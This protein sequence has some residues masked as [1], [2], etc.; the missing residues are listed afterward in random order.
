M[1]FRYRLVHEVYPAEE[2]HDRVDAFAKEPA[3]LPHEAVGVAKLTVDLC[4]NADPT[5]A[6]HVEQLA[7]SVLAFGDEHKGRVA[8]FNERSTRRGNTGGGY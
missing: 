1:K 5:S 4:A 8:A 2:L 6:R 3:G 7:N